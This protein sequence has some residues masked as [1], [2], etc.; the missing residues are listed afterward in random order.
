MKY[1]RFFLIIMMILPWFLFPLLGRKTVKRFLP[2]AIFISLVTTLIH[3][4][5]N[6]QKWWWFYSSIHPKVKGSIPFTFGP[7][8]LTA[9]WILKMTY[10]KFPLFMLTTTM[11]HLL[12]VFPGINL[13]K[14]LGIFSLVRANRFHLFL[15]LLFRGL[16]LYSF[17]F[18]KE[19]IF[20][21]RLFKI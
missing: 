2:A 4:L 7:Q 12:F 9:L 16:L 21:K 11:V 8:F 14:R 10:G 5:A 18:A 15:L 17:Q 3:R 1:S 20:K 13:I 19:T 6:K